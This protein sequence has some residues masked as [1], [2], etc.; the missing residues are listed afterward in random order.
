MNDVIRKRELQQFK[1]L[2][3]FGATIYPVWL[4]YG[5]WSGN[6]D[7]P[8]AVG[9]IAVWAVWYIKH[10]KNKVENSVDNEGTE[11]DWYS[12]PI[13]R[14]IDYSVLVI[15]LVIVMLLCVSLLVVIN[16]LMY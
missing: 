13:Q 5:I 12:L 7:G 10:V 14:Y 15:S 8:I 1:A 6:Y 11:I 2:L 9:F 3:W 4:V 16:I